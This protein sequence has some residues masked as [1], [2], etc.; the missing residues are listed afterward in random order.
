METLFT[1]LSTSLRRRLPAGLTGA[2]LIMAVAFAHSPAHQLHY[3]ENGEIVTLRFALSGL[4]GVTEAT[5][6]LIAG[7]TVHGMTLLPLQD[8][9]RI[10]VTGPADSSVSGSSIVAVSKGESTEIATGPFEIVWFEADHGGSLA[11]QETRTVHSTPEVHAWLVANHGESDVLIRRLLY[12][13]AK[14]ITGAVLVT[15]TGP[16]IILDDV[17]P[18]PGDKFEPYEPASWSGQPYS[19]AQASSLEILLAPG[20]SVG[21]VLSGESFTDADSFTIRRMWDFS[22]WIEY[23]EAGQLRRLLL[24]PR[25]LNLPEL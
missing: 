16:G 18:D 11:H 23:E 24:T 5:D 19:R 13:A 22:P 1:S 10:D 4:P 2:W 14:A 6:I 9:A 25:S 15:G 20:D 21:L 17:L 12:G 8:E 7:A 3:A